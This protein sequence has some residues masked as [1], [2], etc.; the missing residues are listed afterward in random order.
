MTES[1]NDADGSG[2]SSSSTDQS[3]G[4]YCFGCSETYSHEEWK[5]QRY[6]DGRGAAAFCP[7]CGRL[8]VRTRISESLVDGDLPDHGEIIEGHNPGY[9]RELQADTDHEESGP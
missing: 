4:G 3:T 9:L 6:R 2:Q 7:F 8:Q 5:G 1:R